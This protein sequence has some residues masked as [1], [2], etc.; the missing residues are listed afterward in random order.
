VAL[1]GQLE[2]AAEPLEIGSEPRVE[3]LLLLS[4]G[5]DFE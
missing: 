5:A 2:G 4:G 3:L 1:V